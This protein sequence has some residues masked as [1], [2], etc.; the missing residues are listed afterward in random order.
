MLVNV[1]NI[2]LKSLN[3]LV[4]ILGDPSRLFQPERVSQIIRSKL[5]QCAGNS[6]STSITF[7]KRVFLKAGI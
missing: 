3:L 5:Y 1:F 7:F 6:I 2:D 4:I